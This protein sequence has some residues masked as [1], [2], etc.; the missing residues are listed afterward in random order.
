MSDLENLVDLLKQDWWI[1]VPLVS[2]FIWIFKKIRS[3]GDLDLV[4]EPDGKP[5]KKKELESPAR[6]VITAIK[7]AVYGKSTEA[8]YRP[9]HK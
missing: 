4:G 2:A 7:E 6:D 8:S 1:I 5:G 3:Y 9:S